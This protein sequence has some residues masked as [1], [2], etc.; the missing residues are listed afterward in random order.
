MESVL[1]GQ[2]GSRLASD[3]LVAGHHGSATSTSA[4]FLDAV[5][6]RLVLYASGYANHF[7]FPTKEVRDRVAARAIPALDTG[8]T[9][10][11][12]LRLGADGALH[13]PWTW[14]QRSRRV[15][16]HVAGSGDGG[17]D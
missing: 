5:A 1:V 15:W 9:G 8:I 16:T 11:I 6:P 7:G 14:R 17:S 4:R 12:E 13:G 2:F 3:V 10:A